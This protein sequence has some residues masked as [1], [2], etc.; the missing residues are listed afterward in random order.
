MSSIWRER[1]HPRTTQHYHF[2][3]SISSYHCRGHAKQTCDIVCFLYLLYTLEQQVTQLLAQFSFVYWILFFLIVPTVSNK[4]NNDVSI[5]EKLKYCS[6]LT[7]L[8]LYNTRIQFNNAVHNVHSL[9]QMLN[10]LHTN[11]KNQPH[12]NIY[13]CCRNI[14]L[15]VP[16]EILDQFRQFKIKHLNNLTCN[17]T[18]YHPI[19]LLLISI[20]N[21]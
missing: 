9:P 17:I 2:K 6:N 1:K 13:I 15:A 18:Q 19:L 5:I 14:L 12:N 16:V 7:F 4:S 11:Y 3:F 8:T 21:S 20:L 10:I